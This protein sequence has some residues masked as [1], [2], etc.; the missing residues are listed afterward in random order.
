MDLPVGELL[1]WL[2][3]VRPEGAFGLIL[4]TCPWGSAKDRGWLKE[5]G[6]SRLHAVARRE[7]PI[8]S[9]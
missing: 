5:K 7:Y 2:Q 1:L 6:D 3:G 4:W 9:N 8:M